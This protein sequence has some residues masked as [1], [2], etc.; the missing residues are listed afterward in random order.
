M[1]LRRPEGDDFAV[2]L[3]DRMGFT[4]DYLAHQLTRRGAR[5]HMFTSPYRWPLPILRAAYPYVTRVGGLFRDQASES[6]A[7]MVERVDPDFIIPTTE[8]ALYWLWEQS[9]RI[10]ERCLPNVSPEIRS[11]LLDRGLLLQRAAEWG[12]A[13]PD[14]MPLTNLE[15]C[16]AARDKGLPLVV[17][18]G[19]SKA[20]SGV[21]L[22]YTS[23]EV[24]RA[25]T[26]FSRRASP[27]TAQRYY[28]GPTFMAG[29]LFVDGEAVHFYAGEQTIMWPPLTGYS[30]EIQS[31]RESHLSTLL[32][33]T[34]TVC[35][36]LEWT[37]FA[38]FDFV[39]DENDQF[40]FVDF[41]PRL[42]GSSAAVL[43]AGVDLFGGIHRLL[44]HGDAGPPSRSMP[45]SSYRV[46]PKYIMEPSHMSP[47][48]RLG[49]LRDAPWDTPFLIFSELV[50][51]VALRGAELY[52][53]R[54]KKV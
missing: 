48:R 43:G 29:G 7:A 26:E 22:C 8:E 24:V 38:A 9:P 3:V 39:L 23:D 25:F 53:K 15:D 12:V 44:R 18:S 32:E 27:V 14:S 30:Y 36:H 28:F 4:S 13:T 11:L 37:G 5:V 42:W 20:S 17:K 10:Q 2:I 19:Q 54:R 21:A 1:T 49:G 16:T 51:N 45:N 50:F 41:N 40:R 47:W 6:F 52:S 46:F 35:K 31:A 34:E 33:A